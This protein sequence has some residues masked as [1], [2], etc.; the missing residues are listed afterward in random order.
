M[1]NG[2]PTQNKEKEKHGGEMS[3][4]GV[5]NHD[6]DWSHNKNQVPSISSVVIQEIGGLTV[7][8]SSKEREKE[9]EARKKKGVLTR[10][11]CIQESCKGGETGPVDG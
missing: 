9:T 3:G 6:D 5:I 1:E 10:E 4:R 2:P 8:V 11:G 7:L